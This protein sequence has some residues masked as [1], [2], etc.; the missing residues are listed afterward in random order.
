MYNQCN[1]WKK[2][3]RCKKIHIQ[4]L[5]MKS[6]AP[7]CSYCIHCSSCCH[8]KKKKQVENPRTEHLKITMI[9]YITIILEILF[10]F[11]EH[12]YTLGQFLI[13]FVGNQK[14]ERQADVKEMRMVKRL[15][16]QMC[17]V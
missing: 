17:C 15:I 9:Q 6:E 8:K 12:I 11:T 10:V 1:L 16:L 13:E 14:S 4:I 7:L 2:R 5:S 3:G